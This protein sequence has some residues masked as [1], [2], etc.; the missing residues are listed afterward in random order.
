MYFIHT[1][2]WLLASVLFILANIGANGSFVFYDA[3]LPHIA[4]D[5]EIDRVSTAGYALGYLGGGL[6]LALNLAWIQ[7]PAWFGLPVGRGPERAAGDAARPA[8]VPVGRGLVARLLDPAV[9]P[10]ARAAGRRSPATNSAARARSGPRS[11][12]W[13]RRRA[14]SAATARAS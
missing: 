1:G 8:G 9:P 11:H 3:L 5:D 13:P 10:R 12:G 2:D 4:R 7:K 6:L 14:S